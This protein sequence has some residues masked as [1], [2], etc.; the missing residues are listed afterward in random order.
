[1]S[2]RQQ[3]AHLSVKTRF[4]A[5]DGV[6]TFHIYE[7]PEKTPWVA[8]LMIPYFVFFGVACVV[9][10][11]TLVQ[12]GKLLVDKF[13]RRHA[14]SHDA[15]ELHMETLKE[16]L[17]ANKLEIRKI[18]CVLLLGVTEGVCGDFQMLA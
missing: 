4:A 10:V 7:Q 9:S 8:Q 16:K 6:F 15:A 13:R 11:F 17:D 1:L 5:G 2:E 18:Y 14:A 12:K 3:R